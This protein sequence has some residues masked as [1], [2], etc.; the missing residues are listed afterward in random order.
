MWMF[1][2]SDKGWYW[3]LFQSRSRS[4]TYTTYF[5][6]ALLHFKN[7]YWSH[8][9][10]KRTGITVIEKGFEVSLQSE[11]HESADQTHVKEKNPDVCFSCMLTFGCR[12]RDY[13]LRV[14]LWFIIMTSFLKYSVKGTIENLV[15]Y[16]AAAFKMLHFVEC[17]HFSS[18]FDT[19]S[20][21]LYSCG[22]KPSH[23]FNI[24][25]DKQ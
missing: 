11:G 12:F 5:N 20:E 16:V 8:Y 18:I 23:M 2:H 4:I 7:I 25:R 6:M 17:R 24:N 13:I 21:G 15:A 14:D 10:M 3:S 1:L 22:R 19:L 9:T